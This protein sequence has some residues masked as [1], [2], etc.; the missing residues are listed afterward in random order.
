MVHLQPLVI[1]KVSLKEAGVAKREQGKANDWR[2][3]KVH[4]ARAKSQLM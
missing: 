2:T 1:L 3:R 4:K